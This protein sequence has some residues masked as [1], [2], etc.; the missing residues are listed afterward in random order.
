MGDWDSGDR[1]RRRSSEV[2][3]R[4]S[5]PCASVLPSL[6][7]RRVLSHATTTNLS[8]DCPQLRCYGLDQRQAT[9]IISASSEAIRSM[10]V[11]H[12]FTDHKH[13]RRYSQLFQLEVLC[14]VFTL[15]PSIKMA[16]LWKNSYYSL[17]YEEYERSAD[18]DG[19][20]AVAL[21]HTAVGSQESCYGISSS[22][23][24]KRER[25]LGAVEIAKAHF[26]W[27]A[28]L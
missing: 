25:I 11:Q 6:A 19:R 14:V 4:G 27:V 1:H 10:I 24:C 21:G 18:R 5:C 23:L 13:R 16:K 7:R 17:D 8:K 3:R 9:P 2:G 12:A 22:Y 20:S 26:A 15:L 28:L